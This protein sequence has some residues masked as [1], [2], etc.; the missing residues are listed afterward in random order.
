MK[1]AREKL[2]PS[3]LVTA[4]DII[5]DLVDAHVKRSVTLWDGLCP[6]MLA[7]LHQHQPECIDSG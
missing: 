5:D 2:P 3:P 1:A 7:P 6:Q 4:L